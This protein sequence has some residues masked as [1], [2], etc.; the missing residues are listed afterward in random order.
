LA[1]D[2]SIERAKPFLI[3]AGFLV[4]WWLIPAG[5]KLATRSSFREF[6]APIWELA[7]RAEDLSEYW[8]HLS[9]SKKTLIE[10]GRENARGSAALEAKPSIPQIKLLRSEIARL[11][12]ALSMPQES[13]FKAVVARVSR[14]DLS[15]WWQNITLRKGMARNLTVGAGVVSANG[16][17]G[18]VSEVGNRWA[19][20][21]LVTS[22][23]FRVAAQFEG[24][25]RPVTFQGG[26]IPPGG[27]P[28]GVVHNVP[29]D[30]S[31]IEGKPL[32]LL[33]SSLGGTFPAGI[34]IGLVNTLE[35]GED[36]LFKSGRVELD[37]LLGKLREVTV[38][39]PLNNSS[40]ER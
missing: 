17:A 4:V 7:S 25:D 35:G 20:V 40:T 37:E 3:L 11:E 13:G 30:L 18:R 6:Q 10:K 16:V 15:A 14:R 39:L 38:L 34:S 36:G 5:W 9:D 27:K 26:G 21:R 8:G 33:T 29:H 1:S 28:F 22:P 32:R 12:T 2:K 24:D 31:P 19:T 23:Q